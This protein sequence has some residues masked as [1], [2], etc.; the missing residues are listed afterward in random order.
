MFIAGC[1]PG[2]FAASAVFELLRLCDFATLRFCIPDLSRLGGNVWVHECS[3]G[4]H[5]ATES[6]FHTASQ[7]SESR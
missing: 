5:A 2:R 4:L 6:Q 7:I 1:V 3:C